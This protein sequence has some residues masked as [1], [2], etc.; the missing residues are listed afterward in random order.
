MKAEDQQSQR[1][2]LESSARRQNEKILVVFESIV[3]SRPDPTPITMGD[4]GGLIDELMRPALLIPG[5][6]DF[7]RAVLKAMSSEA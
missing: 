4:S 5:P 3:S 1:R 7:D 2:V 6:V